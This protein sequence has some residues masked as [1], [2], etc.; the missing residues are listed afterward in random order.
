VALPPDQ[1]PREP[2][3]S[4]R[5]DARLDASTRQ[6]V[7]ECAAR[8]HRPRSA[9]L[10]HIMHWGLGREHTETLDQGELQGPVRHFSLYVPSRLHEHIEKAA[11]ATGVKTAAWLRHMVR[12]ITVTDFPASWQDA[13]PPERSH[14]SRTYAERFMLRL[15]EPSQTKL[16]QLIKEF[17]ASKAEIIRHLIAR[18]KPKD[19]PDH[20]HLRAA[21]R[22]TQ[23]SQ[24]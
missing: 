21:E 1:S 8:F 9:V 24:R 13:T 20:W 3:A 17:G 16:E 23:Q 12:Q 5:T 4:I 11:T 2:R 10:C 15:D 14:D 22:R 19:F 6:K 7:D 18:A